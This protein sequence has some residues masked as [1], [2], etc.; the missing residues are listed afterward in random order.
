MTYLFDTNI[1]IYPIKNQPQTIAQKVN[2]LPTDAKLAMSFI[3]WAE[4]LRVQSEATAS[5][6]P[7]AG[8]INWPSR[9][10]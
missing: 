7:C 2:S 9:S 8:L 10:M 3:T 1:L 5:Q 4:L 6:K